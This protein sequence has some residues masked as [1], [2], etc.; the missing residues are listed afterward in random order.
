MDDTVDVRARHSSPHTQMTTS[1]YSLTT[2]MAVCLSVSAETTGAADG[3]LTHKSA[4][5]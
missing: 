2:S 1:N 3:T 4:L 5:R